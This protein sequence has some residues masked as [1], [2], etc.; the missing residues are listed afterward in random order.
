VQE[1]ETNSDTDTSDKTK[2]RGE[3]EAMVAAGGG[4]CLLGFFLRLRGGR[5]S[6]IGL[7]F[8]TTFKKKLQEDEKVWW[9]VTR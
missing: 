8:S 7:G 4:S 3:K 1:Q 6:G 9:L 2:F 5:A